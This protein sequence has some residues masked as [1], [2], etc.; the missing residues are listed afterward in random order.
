MSTDNFWFIACQTEEPVRYMPERLLLA[1]LV[2]RNIR[3]LGPDASR[4]RRADAISWFTCPPIPPSEKQNKFTFI[5]IAE[6]LEFSYVQMRCVQKEVEKAQRMNNDPVFLAE[7]IVIG[8]PVPT[9][10]HRV[11]A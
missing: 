11:T 9:Y 6:I 3:D 8:R 2:E 1:A 7:Q 10:R 5:E 4:V